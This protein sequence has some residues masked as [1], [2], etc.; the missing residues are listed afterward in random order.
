MTCYHP[1]DA[2][3][4]VAGGRL[5]FKPSLWKKL[6]V[7]ERPVGIPCRQCIG[8]RL[9]YARDWSLRMMHEASM[10]EHNWFVTLTYRPDVLPEN[11]DLCY[12]DFQKFMKRLRKALGNTRVRFY[13]A[14]E[15]GTKTARPHWHVILFG[16]PLTDLKVY[17][18]KADYPLFTSEWLADIWSYGNVV[19]GEVTPASTNYVAGYVIARDTDKFSEQYLNIDE[20]GVIDSDDDGRIIVRRREFAKCSTNPGIGRKYFDDNC[21]TIMEHDAVMVGKY[22]KKFLGTML[23]FGKN[24]ILMGLRVLVRRVW[25]GLQR[26][27]QK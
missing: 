13:V 10:H 12:S 7:N 1:I 24:A 22:R 26:T 4:P 2:F 27:V 15:Y 11:S 23:K 14:G 8:C 19:I 3:Q 18:R 5:T 17:K 21:L 20:H 6:W 25:N 9:D 16:L